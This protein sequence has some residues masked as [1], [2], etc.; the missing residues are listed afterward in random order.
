MYYNKGF[1]WKYSITLLLF[2]HLL[3]GD[4]QAQSNASTNENKL[5]IHAI[6]ISMIS[7]DGGVFTMGC[8]SDQGSEC[9][10]DEFP[11]HQVQLSSFKL[12]KTEVTQGMW[13][14]VMGNNPSLN[15]RTAQFPVENV[16]FN[17]IEVF[18][19][20]LNK[21]SGHRYR[22]LTEAEW[23]FAARGGNKSKSTLY[24]GSSDAQSV[25]WN[26]GN[27]SNTTHIAGYKN[28]NELGLF[29][30]SG[31]VWEWCSDW[32]GEY[33]LTEE[34]DPRGAV[35]GTDKVIRGGSYS[36]SIWFCRNSIRMHYTPSYKSHIIGF[37]LA[38]DMPN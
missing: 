30:M 12:L 3:L 23:E 22:L 1:Y 8:T 17:D 25:S 28:A 24:S 19:D 16:S 2:I 29:D 9:T 20:E 35:D 36:G 11:I 38:E 4:I 15:K 34:S 5:L 26:V 32:Y 31:N 7:I 6:E 21:I 10:H 13:Q 14:S 37:R 27:S 18:I 33:H